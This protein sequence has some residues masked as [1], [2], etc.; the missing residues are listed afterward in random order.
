MTSTMGIDQYGTDYHNLGPHPRKALLER[1]GRKR[2]SKMYID[3]KDGST[4]H[5]GYIIAGHWIRLFH[6]TSWEKEA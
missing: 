4:K 3:K 6:V 5:V 1:L 2:A